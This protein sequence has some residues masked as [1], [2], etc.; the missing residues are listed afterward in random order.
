MRV[1]KRELRRNLKAFLIWTVSTAMFLAMIVAFYPY[2]ADNA[3]DYERMLEQLP[4]AMLS[5]F[6]LDQLS[7]ADPLGWYGTEGY[8]LFLIFASVYAIQLGAGILSKEEDERTIDFLLAKPISRA[9]IVWEKIWGMNIYLLFFNVI[10][11]AVTFVGLEMVKQQ[12]YDRLTLLYLFTAA[13]MVQ[14][15]FA[16]LGLL[17]S[18]FITKAKAILPLSIGIALGSYIISVMAKMSEQVESLK[19]F[20]PF[21]YAEAGEIVS[22]GRLSPVYMALSLFLIAASLY[23]TLYFYQRKDITA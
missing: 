9:Q 13:Y 15:V 3:M 14:I 4:P 2:I 21:S 6:N 12:A 23:G 22:N 18:V 1:F 10:C 20:T 11:S 17:M 16:S 8:V 19:Y 7:L 5:A